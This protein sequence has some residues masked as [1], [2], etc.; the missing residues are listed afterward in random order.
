[1]CQSLYKVLGIQLC[2]TDRNLA[3]TALMIQQR[4]DSEIHEKIIYVTERWYETHTG[5][6]VQW[7]KKGVRDFPRF[8]WTVQLVISPGLLHKPLTKAHG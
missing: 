3:F 4:L 1:M 2:L 6:Q 8:P 7:G 5:N